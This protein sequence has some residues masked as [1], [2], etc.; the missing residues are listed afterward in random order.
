MHRFCTCG[1]RSPGKRSR[2]GK[3]PASGRNS[4]GH[5]GQDRA[6]TNSGPKGTG[7]A[8]AKKGLSASTALRLE[9][10]WRQEYEAWCRRPPDRDRRV[11]VRAGRIHGALGVERER[12]C[13]LQ[14]LVRVNGGRSASDG[15]GR[16]PRAGPGAGDRR[17]RHGSPGPH[18]RRS[19]PGDAG[20][21]AGSTRV[22]MC[23]MSCRNRCSSTSRGCASRHPEAEIGEAFDLFI[24]TR[25]GRYPMA[26]ACLDAA[27]A[28]S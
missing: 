26:A 11:R 14:V 15:P 27:G 23:S 16:R 4:S 6:R 3:I 2:S 18:G 21:A 8:E 28:S 7:P 24:E 1:G 22:P 5:S 10:A 20:S 13:C 19:G 25:E 12:P 9:P 17:R